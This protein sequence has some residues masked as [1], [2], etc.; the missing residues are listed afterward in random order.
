L[1]SSVDAQLTQL[2]SDVES[3]KADS[4]NELMPVV[5]DDLHVLAER[6]LRREKKGHTLQPTALIHEAYLRLVDQSRVGWKGKTHFFALCATSMRRILVDHARKRKAS[7]RGGEARRVDFD[8]GLLGDDTEDEDILAVD[9]AIIKLANFDPKLARIV[10]LRFFSGLTVADVAEVLQES[11][12]SVEREW[13]M[14]RAWLRREL[15]GAS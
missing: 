5:Y 6:I 11:K 7:K 9:D 14:A 8:I 4:I 13:S 15:S 10:E 12:R 3:G 2:L 1:N